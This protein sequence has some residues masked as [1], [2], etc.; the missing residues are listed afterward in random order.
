MMKPTAISRVMQCGIG[1]FNAADVC[2]KGLSL[3]VI[4]SKA[5]LCIMSGTWTSITPCNFLHIC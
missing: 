5:N 3:P 2:L 1:V 4:G